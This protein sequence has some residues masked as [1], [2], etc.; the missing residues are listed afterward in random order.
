MDSDQSLVRAVRLARIPHYLHCYQQGLTAKELAELC[1]VSVRT[2]QRDINSLQYDLE[3]PIT[4]DSNHYGI[5]GDYV[6]P[7]I[8]FS[9]YEAVALFLAS[10]L[11]VRH[12][13]EYNPHV[14]NALDKMSTVLPDNLSGRVKESINEFR[15][16]GRNDDFVH[17]FEIISLA[18]IIRRQI[19]IRYQSLQNPEVRDWLLEPYFVEMSGVGDSSYVIGHAKRED[20]EGLLTFKLDRIKEAKLTSKNFEIPS[21]INIEEHLASSWGVVWGDEVGVD[22]ELKFS[23]NVTRRIKESTWHPSQV[24]TDLPDGGCLFKLH[25]GSLLEI[26]PWIRSWGP[27]VEVIAPADLRKS[28]SAWAEQLVEKYKPDGANE[29]NDHG[30]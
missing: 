29:G 16:K 1:G 14:A 10:R 18:W 28:F 7:P 25:I 11:A 17:I 3:I 9:L 27:D 19:A 12:T 23:R 4:Q 21:D 8:C 30:E 5:L 6:L 15:K 26:T 24:I 2:I 13:D 20:R 22:V